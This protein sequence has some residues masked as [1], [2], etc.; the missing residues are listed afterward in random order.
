[1]MDNELNFRVIM[2]VAF[3]A[4][5]TTGV[6]HRVRAAQSGEKISRREEGLPIMILLR[7]FGFSA[8]IGMLIY[9]VNP[10][11]MLWSTLSLP[12]W[13]RWVGAG[14]G[15]VAVPLI[16]WMFRSLG[17]NVTDTVAIRKEHSLVTYGPYRWVRHPMYSITLLTVVGFSLLSA[18]WF[19]G[20]TGIAA[21]ALIVVRI[22][23]EER[24]LIEEFGEE[25][26]Q[27]MR[28]TGRL[29]PRSTRSRK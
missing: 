5:V 23:I 1:M 6:Y 24:K 4:V 28:R 11:W 22:P 14:F 15:I 26:R 12:S 3:I 29:V 7:L 25:Y 27:Y 2:I 18:N 10:R 17:N 21:L 16:H 8:W 13:C 20:L 9:M 19:I